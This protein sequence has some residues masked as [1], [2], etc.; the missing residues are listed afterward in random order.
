M[1]NII[2]NYDQSLWIYQ[3]IIP[4]IRCKNKRSGNI[5][6]MQC[7]F[8]NEAH[9]SSHKSTAIRGHYFIDKQ[10]YWCYRCNKWAT[11]F[12]LYEILSGLSRKDL[13]PEYLSFVNSS[14]KRGVN[15]S[16]Y[17]RV[18]GGS[19]YES[20]STTDNN[21]NVK[22]DLLPIPTVMK[23]PLTQR[24]LDYLNNRLILKS[25]NLPD[26]AKFYSAMYRPK[27]L[28]STNDKAYEVIVI[29]WYIDGREWSYQWRFLDND[30]PFAKY[31]FPKNCGKK[32]YGIDSISTSFPYIICCE[33]V[34][35]SLWVKNGIAVGG[36]TLTEYQRSLL[37]ERFPKHRIV[38]GFDNDVHGI[39][40]MF[41]I[42]GNDKN[43]L[44]FYW[45]HLSNGAKDLND[46]AISGNSEYFFNTDNLMKCIYNPVQL[47]MLLNNPFKR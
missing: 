47:K 45:K 26:Y 30:I 1:S 38:Y 24:G 22:I 6:H 28:Y 15:L 34:F 18:G 5:H 9:T 12:E 20:N 13:M 19:H 39:N 36:K 10:N 8:C 42:S 2:K 16:N 14:N 27:S 32:I 43:A 4:Y 25:P 46:F 29:P 17:L 44:I 40:A 3:K 23:N 31:G 33:G 21:G 37:K 35:D 41:K 11:A 7:P